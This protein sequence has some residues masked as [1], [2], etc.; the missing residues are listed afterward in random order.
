LTSGALD[1]GV[2]GVLGQTS[3]TV[4]SADLV[5]KGSTE[6]TVSVD[7]IALNAAGETLLQ[8]KLRLEN[9]LVVETGVEAVVLLADVVCRNARAQRVGRG[10]DQRKIDTLL[11]SAKVIAGLEKLSTANHLIDTADTKLGHDSPHLVGNVVEEVD[12][13]LRCAIEL[14]PELGV[15]SSNTD[16]TGVQVAFTYIAVS[17]LFHE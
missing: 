12:D 8:S 15:L 10:Q 1:V 11:L 14:L 17:S 7:N 3:L 13:M 4:A 6:G 16:R 2:D 5:R 9:Q